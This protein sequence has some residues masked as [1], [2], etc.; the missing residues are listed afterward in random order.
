M[1]A[2]QMDSENNLSFR[3]YQT[4]SAG[5]SFR[6]V[7][8][9]EKQDRDDEVIEIQPNWRYQKITGFG[10][11][12]TES[13]SYLLQNLSDSSRNEVLAAYFSD[14]GARYSLCRTHINSCDFSLD[15][16]AYA[17]RPGD[18]LLKDFSIA[19]DREYLIPTIKQAMEVSSEGFKLISSPWTAPPWM[20]SNQDWNGGKLLKAYYP[21]WALYFSKYLKAYEDEGIPI[22][23]ITVE[24]EPLGN[25][26][27]WE[28]M[29][30]TPHEMAEFVKEH[31]GPQLSR[32]K[33]N[34]KVLVYDQNRGKE[35]EEWAKILLTDQ[36]LLPYIYGT[37][38]HWYT[39]TIDWM[40]AS[41]NYT[42][43]LAPKKSII[44]TEACVDADKPR[45]KNDEWYWSK[46]ATDWGW[47]WAAEEDKKDHP[48]Y[49]PV[50]RYARDI[51]GCLNSWVEGWIDW[52]MV[53]DPE[54]GPNLAQNW[55]NAPVIVDIESDE[56][57]YTPLYYTLMHFSKFIRPGAERIHLS[58][59]QEAVMAAAARNE[60]GSLVL[61]ILNEDSQA[62]T[63]KI[64]LEKRTEYLVIDAKAIQTLVIKEEDKI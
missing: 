10:G 55:C 50:F 42:H 64:K 40:P 51:I 34:T 13:T 57:Y 39:S 17:N 22:W 20:K 47:D 33:S 24:N 46:E 32:D 9:A 18:S 45:W 41:L 19:H 38:V 52:N 8:M 30:F 12:F 23:A 61:V 6:E 60:D 56:V 36:K 5:D 44:H 48:K 25:D 28:S 21:T 63:I 27:N 15:H 2:C 58:L 7:S 31:L 53:L 3:L 29:H 16:Y 11:A 59:E 43:D 14:Q 54:G 37:A 49:V 35:L 4:S 26:S 1:N 62:K